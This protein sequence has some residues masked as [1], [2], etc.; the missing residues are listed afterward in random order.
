[1]AGDPCRVDFEAWFF[2]QPDSAHL[3]VEW[4]ALGYPCV[5]GTPRGVWTQVGD[6]WG[7]WALFV[8]GWNA[9]KGDVR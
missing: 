3:R 7:N 5:Y 4:D 8:A 2:K 1:M 9:A 6:L